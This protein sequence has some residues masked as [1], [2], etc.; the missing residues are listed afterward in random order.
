METVLS[1]LGL[2]WDGVTPLWLA[3]GLGIVAAGATLI[4]WLLA[5]VR[6]HWP[7]AVQGSALVL[8]ALAMLFLTT[9]EL[10]P[11]AFDAGVSN[12]VVLASVSAGVAVVMILSRLGRRFAARHSPLAVTG[13]VAAVAI[14]LHNIP[15]GAITVGMSTI[16]LGAAVTA[17]LVIA[18]HNVPEGLAVAAPII[19]AGAGRRRALL[20]VGLVT[21]GE[22]AGVLIAA[23]FAVAL[24]GPG[25]GV[26]L[27]LVSGIMLAVST[28]EL[29]PSGLALI[30]QAARRAIP[31]VA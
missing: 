21:A 24:A 19:A 12:A 11:E 27:A 14:G 5:A 3:I 6:A 25:I 7:L 1:S 10:L 23:Q 18:A 22:V 26:L 8:A 29:L 20:A 4:G 13:M 30:R 2:S 9:T 17:T 31:V 15:E 16:S 28:M